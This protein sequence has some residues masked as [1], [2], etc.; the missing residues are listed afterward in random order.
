[1]MLLHEQKM[2]PSHDRIRSHMNKASSNGQWSQIVNWKLHAVCAKQQENEN[3]EP[4]YE[5]AFTTQSHGW[6]WIC[7]LQPLLNWT[8]QC[9]EIWI[10][11]FKC[12][13]IVPATYDVQRESDTDKWLIFYKMFCIGTEA[14]SLYPLS[15]SC[16]SKAAKQEHLYEL[17]FT[18]QSHG[19]N[20][21][22][23]LQPLLN[24]T[25]QSVEIWICR[26]KCHCIV[27]ATYDVQRESDTD[28]WLVSYK[29][30]CIRTEA[31]SL[32]PLSASCISKPQNR[33]MWSIKLTKLTSGHLS[34]ACSSS[35][36]AQ[37]QFCNWH[38]QGNQSNSV[39]AT[40]S[41]YTAEPEQRSVLYS[42]LARAQQS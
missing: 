34:V 7:R 33:G 35:S 15:V 25:T 32:Y 16:F 28:K 30:F 5:L 29:M 26:F 42:Q 41:Q 10:Y 39:A 38:M 14:L 23:R 9:V 37:I 24:W 11:R 40:C 22:C 8:T 12:D 17:A 19:W 27:P 20:W 31:L 2:K 13:C 18:T 4:L 21:I 3:N 36:K 6:N 1:M